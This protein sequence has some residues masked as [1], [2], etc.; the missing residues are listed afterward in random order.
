[1]ERLQLAEKSVKQRAV[2][3]AAIIQNHKLQTVFLI[4]KELVAFQKK[5][6]V[7]RNR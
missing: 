3:K 1:M 6:H 2:L 7:P 5:K 4:G